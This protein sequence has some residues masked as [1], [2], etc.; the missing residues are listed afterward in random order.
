MPRWEIPMEEL[1]RCKVQSCSDP[2]PK[3][4]KAPAWGERSP[5]HVSSS[6]QQESRLGLLCRSSLELDL[7]S[8]NHQG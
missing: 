7:E 3:R 5:A 2:A 8:R 4:G 6:W 1:S